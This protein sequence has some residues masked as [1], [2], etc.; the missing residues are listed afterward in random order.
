MGGRGVSQ[1]RQQ[2]FCPH[3][4]WFMSRRAGSTRDSKASC[5]NPNRFRLRFRRLSRRHLRRCRC[6][7]SGQ[8]IARRAGTAGSDAKMFKGEGIRNLIQKINFNYL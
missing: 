2:I 7:H 6:P 4:N 1:K 3:A 8:E 5:M